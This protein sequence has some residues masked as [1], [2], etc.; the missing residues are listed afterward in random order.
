LFPPVVVVANHCAIIGQNS[1]SNGEKKFR[2]R[3]ILGSII[4]TSTIVVL[5]NG[6]FFC[7]IF[8][9]FP[10]VVVVANH[11]AIIGLSDFKFVSVVVIVVGDCWE[12]GRKKAKEG[13]FAQ[14]W[15]SRVMRNVMHDPHG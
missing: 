1:L 2:R 5:Y 10:P 4:K 12:S 14:F 6:S 15:P 9:L 13:I 3:T 7:H 8:C 11:C